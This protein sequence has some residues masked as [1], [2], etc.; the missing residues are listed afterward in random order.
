MTGY[1]DGW[2]GVALQV[3]GQWRSH[4]DGEVPGTELAPCRTPFPGRGLLV[5][6]EINQHVRK[7]IQ[8]FY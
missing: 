4:M 7:G 5:A 2:R 3:A 8:I 1:T 6:L